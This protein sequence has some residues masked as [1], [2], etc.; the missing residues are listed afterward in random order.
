MR[1]RFAVG[2]L[3]LGLLSTPAGAVQPYVFVPLDVP[4]ARATQARSIND[5]GQVVG[6]FTDRFRQPRFFRWDGSTYTTL[7]LPQPG[8]VTGINDAGLVVGFFSDD[9]GWRG[10]VSD[11]A[12][13]TLFG[14]PFPGVFSMSVGGINDLN[15]IVG[16]FEAAGTGGHGFLKEGEIYTVLD[17]PGASFSGTSAVGINDA[18]QIV[19]YYTRI[20]GPCPPSCGG[21]A[22]GFLKDGDTYTTLDFPVPGARTLA[23]GIN[24][25]GQ[26]VGY[27]H[28]AATPDHPFITDGAS[29]AALE[30][31]GSISARAFDINDAGQ[32]V[33]WFKDPS[34]SFHGFLATPAVV[35]LLD[36]FDAAVADGTLV[37]SGP[38]ASGE[39]RL[40]ALRSMIETAAEL[41]EAG[42][43]EDACA[44]LRE[45]AKRTDEQFPPPDF[46]EGPSAL[47]L[48]E[49]IVELREALGCEQSS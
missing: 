49:K 13:H 42:L 12:T 47:A 24:D 32:I 37:G 36:D 30:V 26:I 7:S 21:R 1:T 28:F 10:Y 3:V 18:G 23:L 29:W 39:G 31:P 6:D 38:G 19:G 45:A 43:L 48:S 27:Y 44:P 9:D 46:V 20:D 40:S 33:G 16:G 41:L 5:A 35:Q 2:G 14:V 22:H 4:G 25:P 34:E 17:V 11:G 8:A 15:Q